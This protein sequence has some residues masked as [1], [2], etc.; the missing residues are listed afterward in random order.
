MTGFRWHNGGA[1]AVHGVA[2]DLSAWG[3]GIANGFA[4]SALADDAR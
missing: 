1:Q 3:K 4:L 2:P